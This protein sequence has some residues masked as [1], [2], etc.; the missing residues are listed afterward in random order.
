MALSQL[1]MEMHADPTKPL[2]SEQNKIDENEWILHHR[3]ERKKGA[4]IRDEAVVMNNF[5]S[6]VNVTAVR[7]DCTEREHLPRLSTT[8]S[9]LLG[10]D[11]LYFE[12]FDL[13]S[14]ASCKR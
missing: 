7:T 12:T 13:F 9:G 5:I 2:K 11:C 1:A 10:S 6:N 8:V 14:I 3:Y 4:H